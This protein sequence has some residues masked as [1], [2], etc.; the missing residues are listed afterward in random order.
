M[1][2]GNN[3]G[4]GMQ[5]QTRLLSGDWQLSQLV[6]AV[7][8]GLIIG[9]VQ[10]ILAISF[11]ALIFAGPLSA[12]VGQG[13]GL[14]LF[15]ALL[16][17]LAVTFLSSLPGTVA[18]NQ[19]IPAAIMAVS[20]ATIVGAMTAGGGEA[21]GRQVFITVVVAIGLTTVLT[22]LFF[23]GLGR[24]R[25]GSLVRYLPY[26]VLGGFLA[27][28]GWLLMVGAM[29]IMV[30]SLPPLASLPSLLEPALLLR[31]LPGVLLA[32]LI[33][34]V[35][36]RTESAL[37]LPAVVLGAV[38]LFYTAAA[39]GGSGAATLSDGGWLLGP[40]P[41]GRLWPALSPADLRLVQWPVLAGQAVNVATIWLMSTVA[42]LLNASGLE[43]A[44]DR[45]MDLNRELRAAGV[46]NVAA[47]LGGGL[48]GYHQ[49]SLSAMSHRLGAGSRVVPLVAAILCG[50]VLVAGGAALSFFPKVV[51]GGLLFFL[52][53]SFI[54]EWVVHSW[55]VLPRTDYAIILLIL[56]V[57]AVAG[58][59]PAVGV[60]LLV[61]VGLFVVNYSRIDIVRDE[62]TGA[63][64]QSRVTR[65][66]AQQQLLRAHAAQLHVLRLQGY[67]FFGT[68]D[69]LLAR[70][71]RRLEQGSPPRF[72]LLD[73][74]RITGIDSTAL[75]SFRRMRQLAQAQ[76]TNLV[77]SDV[78]PPIRR[79]LAGSDLF[80]ENAPV[81]ADLDRA[82][83]W[84]EEQLLAEL[85]EPAAHSHGDP[86]RQ[87]LLRI[88]DWPEVVERLLA[89]FERREVAQGEYLM[90]QGDAPDVLYLIESGQVTAQLEEGEGRPARLQTMAGG[91]VLGELGFFLGLERTAAVVADVPCVVY[92]LSQQALQRM[93]RQDPAMASALHQLIVHMLAERVVHLVNVVSA[94]QQ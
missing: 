87:E 56:L 90:R 19:D 6:S 36:Q 25:L 81:F 82:C 40:F 9:L 20:A 55:A 32:L 70:V 88:L 69:R 60:G 37:A 21:A 12:Y 17:G 54:V 49:L 38:A 92:C 16:G 22:G 3:S 59:L 61:A 72:L 43:L 5:L 13:I 35:L 48:V 85:D 14:A 91:H 18:G 83:E 75:W 86:L 1:S 58:F 39:L 29:G 51:L 28:T 24:F 44:T 78:A 94:L 68:A 52:G 64:V 27:G 31:W 79:Q 89:Y 26:P 41:S 77:L 4:D 66:P 62:V 34:F 50:V 7:S 84:C 45:E 76:G 11:A 33:V 63:H 15:A 23:Y 30:D 10:V 47:G 71:R 53:L 42:L 74:R 67:I 93:R 65:R 2:T 80:D 73:F 57:T 46:G 8:G